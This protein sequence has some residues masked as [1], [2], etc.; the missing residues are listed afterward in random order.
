M[1]SAPPRRPAPVGKSLIILDTKRNTYRIVAL[2]VFRIAHEI[3]GADG[4]SEERIT[5]IAPRIQ[6]NF[7][8]IVIITR[9]GEC[10]CRRYVGLI[11][12]NQSRTKIVRRPIEVPRALFATQGIEGIATRSG[13]A[14]STGAETKI[15]KLIVR[16]GRKNKNKKKPCLQRKKL[17]TQRKAC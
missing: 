16:A 12:I 4:D 13:V 1:I 9:I 10:R 7:Q 6:N 2:H 5:R 14:H 17:F 11:R 3:I 8:L 15:L